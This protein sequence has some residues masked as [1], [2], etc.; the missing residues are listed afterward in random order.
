[1]KTLT[2]LPMLL[3]V[4]PFTLGMAMTILLQINELKELKKPRIPLANWNDENAMSFVYIS[5]RGKALKWH[6]CLKQSGVELNN[7]ADFPPAVLESFAPAGNARTA[8]VN[9]HKVRQ[10]STE[11]VVGFYA[12]VISIKDELQLLVSAAA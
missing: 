5:L 12:H 11:D 10:Q 1:M 8:T 3:F 2:F 4:Y 7:F 6:E 9:L